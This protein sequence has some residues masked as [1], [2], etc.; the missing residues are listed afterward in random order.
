[1]NVLIIEDERP[2]SRVLV[3]LLRQQSFG[4]DACFDG[5]SGE[6]YAL[7]GI[8]DVIILDIQLPGKN[9]L[10]VLRAIRRAGVSTPVL[11]LTAR[12]EVEDKIAGLDSGADDYLTKPFSSGELI[13]RIRAMTRRKGEFTGD[14]LAIAQTR[15]SKV[16]HELL[17]GSNRIK[18]GQKEYGIMEFLMQNE[19]Q[20]I[21]KERFI[22]KIWGYDSEAEYNAIEVYISFLRK[23]LAAISSDLQIKAY[24]GIGYG[25][26]ADT[27]NI[28]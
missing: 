5:I 18:L 16:T 14:E 20:I 21:P 3:D 13:A 17:C 26:S 27:V 7:S 2:L 4:A 25:V 11:L 6:E 9:G 10:D 22:E 1:M 23:K 24:R 12:S 8:Y 15:L 19:R 28:E